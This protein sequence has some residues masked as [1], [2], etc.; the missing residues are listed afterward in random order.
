MK[1]THSKYIRVKI[2]LNARSHTPACTRW[3]ETVPACRYTWVYPHSWLSWSSYFPSLIP[4]TLSRAGSLVSCS[5][6]VL[7]PLNL[8][9]ILS[10]VLFS[11]P[12]FWDT[13][14]LSTRTVE[15]Y[16]YASLRS[17]TALKGYLVRHSW[18]HLYQCLPHGTAAL[19][20][21]K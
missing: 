5:H 19:W 7:V 14:L 15:G 9:R 11:F 8:D 4:R 2:S 18:C 13:Q 12:F 21:C 1:S 20:N 16:V 17:M 3:R 10:S 6:L